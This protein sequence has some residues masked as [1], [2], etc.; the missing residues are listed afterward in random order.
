MKLDEA[1]QYPIFEVADPNDGQAWHGRAILVHRTWTL[2]DIKRALEGMTSHKEDVAKY[3]LAMEGLRNS[4]HLKGS[5]VQQVY[6]Q[7]L[8]IDWHKVIGNWSP[9]GTDGRLPST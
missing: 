9:F 5:E 3:L 8:G 7:S 1:E 4:Y 6:M 2:E